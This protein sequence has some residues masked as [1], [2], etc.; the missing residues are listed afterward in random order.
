MLY[1]ITKP[2]TLVSFF[3]HHS[4]DSDRVIVRDRTGSCK[5]GLINGNSNRIWIIIHVFL[6]GLLL[7]VTRMPI[8]AVLGYVM[9]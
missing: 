8:L 3:Y 6:T 2:M 5:R 1:T 9:V 4:L 7:S